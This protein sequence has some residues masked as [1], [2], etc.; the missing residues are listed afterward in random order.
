[1]KIIKTIDLWTEQHANHFECFSGAFIDG[2]DKYDVFDKYKIIRNCNCKIYV[3][4]KT[5][6]ISNKHQAIVF[7]KKSLPVR[8]LVINKETNIEKCLFVALSQN[9]KGQEL[10]DYFLKLKI[11]SQEINLKEKPIYNECDNNREIDVGSCDRW[12]LLYNMLKGSYTESN[13]QYG[14]YQ[15]DKYE[16]MS[17]IIIE[18]YLKIDTEIFEIKHKCAFINILKTR[19]VPIQEN[20][21]LTSS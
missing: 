19:I 15:T 12:N 1:M 7:Y 13:T 18:Y 9:F 14:N 3:N 4:N 5:I 2:F 8:L 21:K 10:R 16:F 17:D 6:N 11:S 20:S